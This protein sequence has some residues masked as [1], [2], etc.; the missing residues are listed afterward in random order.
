M[1]TK[2]L[3]IDDFKAFFKLVSCVLRVEGSTV[4]N[5]ENLKDAFRKIKSEK[6]NLILLDLNLPK[7]HGFSFLRKTKTNPALKEIPII[8]VSGNKEVKNTKKAMEL[9]ADD[10]ITK[11]INI[12]D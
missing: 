7:E 11:P 3:I 2:V 6:P 12:Q 4:S 9:W 10:Y 1:D 5:T 8:V